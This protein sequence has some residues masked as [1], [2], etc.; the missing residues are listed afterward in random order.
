ML[1]KTD[2]KFLAHSPAVVITGVSM[3]YRTTSRKRNSAE[4]NSSGNLRLKKLQRQT[5]SVTVAALKNT[6]LIVEH[7]ESLGIIGRNGSGKS[8]LLKIISGQIPPTSGVVYAS[9]TPVML[10][11]NAAL[12]PALSGA[13]N[14]VL[15]CLAMGMSYS[16]ID[17][18]YDSIVDLAG[19]GPAIHHPMK[20]Y[21]SGMASRLRFAIAASI[22]PEILIIDEALNTGDAQ[23]KD[24]TRKRMRE[25]LNQAGTVFLV[26]HSLSTII[27]LCSRVIWLDDGELIFDGEPAMAAKLYLDF[28]RKL[29]AE[30]HAGA[31][32]LRR[33]L[34]QDLR[35]AH[36][37]DRSASRRVRDRS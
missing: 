15:G 31:L 3:S 10:G 21:S 23:F 13:Q 22:D 18:K 6:S 11:V 34:L 29:A 20:S 1:V 19:I 12:L 9:A 26:S 25:L 27:E 28:T 24:R 5:T 30:D 7:G 2:T 35:V 33:L 36:A 32:K 16:E 4:K 17:R 8:T 14:V 37:F